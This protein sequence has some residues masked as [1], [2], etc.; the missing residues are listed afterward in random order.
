MPT[1]SEGPGPVDIPSYLDQGR[2]QIGPRIGEGGSGVVHRAV[3]PDGPCAVKFR[4]VPER[5]IQ[6]ARFLAEPVP[7][8]EIR[9][10]NVVRVLK[11]GREHGFYW[12]AMELFSNG[13]LR[14]LV[15]ASGPPPLDDAFR[16]IEE[17]LD[18]LQAVHDAGFIHR[19]IKPQ[20][21][22]L[23]DDGCAAIGDFGV[24]RHLRGKLW[25]RTRTGQAIG[26]MGYR[27]PEQD[28]DAKDA[29]PEADIYGV[30]ATLFFLVTGIRPP[31][32][33]ASEADPRQLEPLPEPLR[34]IVLKAT[35]YHPGDRFGSAK[36]LKAALRTVRNAYRREAGLPEVVEVPE[37]Q[38]SGLRRFLM[39]WIG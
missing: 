4:P 36:E 35:A 28:N 15:K 16:L 38:V 7:M 12:I 14:D 19:D 33:Y 27:A 13:S 22:F 26:T 23:N 29:G 34:P 25:F 37:P 31:L 11:T 5:P 10:P 8:S 1:R 2:Y 32:L 17:V 9:H 30:A 39:R 18:G 6:A 21:I 24:A 20:N 3:G